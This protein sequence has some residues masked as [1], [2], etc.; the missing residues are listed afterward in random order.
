[1]DAILWFFPKPAE[2]HFS[3]RRLEHTRYGN[4]C[5]LTDQPARIVHDYHGSI[6]EISNTL[7]VFLALFQNEDTH[8]LAGKDHW[9]ESIRELINIEHTNTPK[10]GDFIQVEVVGDDNCIEL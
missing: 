1:M 8:C 6:V 10:L 9:F 3:R 7:I 4:I 2:N 5:V